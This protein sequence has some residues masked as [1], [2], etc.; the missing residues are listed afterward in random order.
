M[1]IFDIYP[2]KQEKKFYR[3][4]SFRGTI[5]EYKQVLSESKTIY[6]ANLEETV[7]EE[8]IWALFGMC[9]EIKRVI[10]GINRCTQLPCGFCF[11]EFCEKKSVDE[12]KNL[13]GVMLGGKH[14]KVDRDI[15]FQNG[16]QFGRGFFGNQ[17]QIDQKKRVRYVEIPV[18]AKR[19]KR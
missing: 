1:T 11:V 8:K 16:R 15:G 10:M 13:R 9:G 12:A 7:E 18:D 14:I 5:E 17:Q 19:M 3:D 2:I 4:K 6:V